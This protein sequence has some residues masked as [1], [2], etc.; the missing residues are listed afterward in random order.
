MTRRKTARLRRLRNR[1][2]REQALLA[3][4]VVQ[5]YPT[6]E[7]TAHVTAAGIRRALPTTLHALRSL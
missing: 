6:L 5:A 1:I 7:G 4:L 3:W 2:A